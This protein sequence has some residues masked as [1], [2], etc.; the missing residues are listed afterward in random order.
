MLGFWY[1]SLKRPWNMRM[2]FLWKEL[3]RQIWRLY[4]EKIG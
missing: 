4:Y 1:I 2:A 3:E